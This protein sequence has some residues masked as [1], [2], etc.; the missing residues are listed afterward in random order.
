MSRVVYYAA[1]SADG[2]IARRDGSVDWLDRFNA[3][4]LGYESFLARVGAVVLGRATYEQ[5]LAFGPWP[6]APRPGLVVTSSA[7]QHLL[8]GVRAIAAGALPA[9]VRDLRR[10][11][12]GDVWIVGGGRTARACLDAGLLEELEV[13]VVPVLLGDGIPLLAPRARE[14]PLRLIETR[15]FESGVV[16]TRHAVG[17]AS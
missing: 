15:A 17:G 3:P 16:M 2:F 13:Y 4:E 8:D 9:E 1:A 10:R 6:Y 5:A 14:V 12:D 11:V 7:V